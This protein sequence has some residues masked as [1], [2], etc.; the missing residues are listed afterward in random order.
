MKKLLMIA[1]LVPATIAAGAVENLRPPRSGVGLRFSTFGVP[2]VLLDAFL[3][4]H[5]TVN[6]Q[7]FTFEV[8]SYGD[9]GP[10]STFSGVFALEYSRL[11]GTGY[12]REEQQ[13]V[14]KEGG[15]EVTQLSATATIL[16]HIFP[17]LPVHPYIGAGIGLGRVSIWSEGIHRD[18]LGTEVKDTYKETMVIPVGH[19]PV[20]IIA[21][22]S[23]RFEIRLEGGF[24]NGFYL[25]GGIVY[26]FR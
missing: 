24:K 2:D 7:G 13:D 25:G 16:M 9:K 23:R 12:W 15:G 4:E 14:R 17:S 1:L 10:R 22:L 19:V 6:G 26:T 5:P 21:R 3:Y 20:G 11:E 8:R 18:E